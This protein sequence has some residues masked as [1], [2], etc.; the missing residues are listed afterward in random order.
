VVVVVMRLLLFLLSLTETYKSLLL[1]YL[2][3]RNTHGVN[4]LLLCLHYVALQRGM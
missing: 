4:A 1:V 2:P 3:G